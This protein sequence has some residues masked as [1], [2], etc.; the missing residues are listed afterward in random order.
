MINI[1]FFISNSNLLSYIDG[2]QT[3]FEREPLESL[4]VA[5]ELGAFIH[6]GFWQPVDTIREKEILE[7]QL[8]KKALDWQ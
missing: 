1:G 2:K 6:K 8:N 7:D 3:I 4:T 5:G